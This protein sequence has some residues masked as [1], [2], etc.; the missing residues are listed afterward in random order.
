MKNV[1]V[2]GA[3]GYLG[4]QLINRL[5][6]EEGVERIIGISRRSPRVKSPKLKFYSHDISKPFDK[7]FT[8]NNVDTA[9]HLA[10]VV[11]ATRN[12]KAARAT[13]I[14]GS[15]N[16]LNACKS[17]SVQRVSFVSSYSA[18]GAHPDNTRPLDEDAPLRPNAGFAYSLHK[19]EVDKKF[20]EFM[21]QNPDKHVS[22]IR[23]VVIA[24]PESDGGPLA[25]FLKNPVTMCIKGHDPEWQFIHEEDLTE[26]MVLLLSKG[27]KGVFNA[28]GDGRIG[29]SRMMSSIGKKCITMPDQ[30]GTFITNMTWKL[31]LQSDAPGGDSMAMLK[32]PIIVNAEKAKKE[33]GFKFKYTGQETF[34]SF[35]DAA[36]KRSKK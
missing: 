8:E 19:A 10:F 12:I 25:S 17:A 23:A 28:A 16:F 3:S 1:V 7:I 27:H 21:G 24:G 31:H 14:G 13:D 18:Y 32:Y 34:M 26:L 11:G 5:D 6:R 9:I 30:L 36:R 15:E 33:T 35:L 4:R 20:Q 2:T 29:Y 22:I